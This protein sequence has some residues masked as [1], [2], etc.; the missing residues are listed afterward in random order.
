MIELHRFHRLKNAGNGGLLAPPVDGGQ[1]GG[2][3]R[4]DRRGRDSRA[5][6]RE[7]HAHT[8]PVDGLLRFLAHPK[9]GM[10][11]RQLA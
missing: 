7:L 2:D 3:Q 6:R 11:A 9:V 10:V 8:Q 4:F 1:V 5:L